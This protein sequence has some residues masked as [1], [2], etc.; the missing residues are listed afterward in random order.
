[1]YH[2]TN[3]AGRSS[4][5]THPKESSPI[6]A[7][8]AT[9]LLSVLVY[10]YPTIWRFKIGVAT[11]SS[12][13][14]LESWSFVGM[15]YQLSFSLRYS[16]SWLTFCRQTHIPA[17]YVKS[18]LF[19]KLL[20]RHQLNKMQLSYLAPELS[21]NMERLTSFVYTV[22]LLA[23]FPPP[24][25]L[26]RHWTTTCLRLRRSCGTHAAMCWSLLP[27]SCTS[28]CQCI[29]CVREYIQTSSYFEDFL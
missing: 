13:F 26:M 17:I 8:S 15:Q 7:I 3:Y 10:I 11:L 20:Y 18:I 9:L 6:L 4:L 5:Q 12:P 19:D 14:S 21:V 1:M 22:K 25:L 16:L 29:A 24:L 23:Y 2:S 27:V 28:G